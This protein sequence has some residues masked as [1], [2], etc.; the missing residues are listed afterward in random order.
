M[1]SLNDG[2]GGGPYE[3]A[4]ELCSVTLVVAP[5]GHPS[6]A[7]RLCSPHVAMRSRAPGLH[8]R[9]RSGDRPRETLNPLE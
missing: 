2:T 7:A 4:L 9:S 1:Y 5:A 8:G 3:W 6:S